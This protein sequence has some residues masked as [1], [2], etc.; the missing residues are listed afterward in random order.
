M[1]Y[2]FRVTLSNLYGNS[3]S[4]LKIPFDNETSFYYFFGK[5]IIAFCPIITVYSEVNGNLNP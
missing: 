2:K 4:D 3:N 1:R 5:K